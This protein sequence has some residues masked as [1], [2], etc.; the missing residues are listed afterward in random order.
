MNAGLVRYVAA[1]ALR[2]AL[3]VLAVV[4]LVFLLVRPTGLLRPKEARA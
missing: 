2:A 4:T 1:R 3:T